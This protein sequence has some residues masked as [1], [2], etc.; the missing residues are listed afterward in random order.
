MCVYDYECVSLSSL[1]RCVYDYDE[2]VS[3]LSGCACMSMCLLSCRDV[4][5][6]VCVSELCKCLYECVSLSCADVCM[7]V[8]L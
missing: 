3:E 1:R 4:C 8:C 2:C 7:S 5:V 6:W